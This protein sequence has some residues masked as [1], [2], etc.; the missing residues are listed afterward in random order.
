MCNMT[1]VKSR[2]FF[3]NWPM[4]GNVPTATE[5]C[6]HILKGSQGKLP[7]KIVDKFIPDL[8][9]AILSLK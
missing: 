8:T 6:G 7:D 2:P 9:A 5:H 1:L 3:K 4:K